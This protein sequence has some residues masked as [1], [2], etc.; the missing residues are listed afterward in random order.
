M[1]ELGIKHGQLAL[2]AIFYQLILLYPLREFEML[3]GAENGSS[4]PTSIVFSFFSF[5]PKTCIGKMNS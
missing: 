3:G 1:A 5:M 4:C 2:E